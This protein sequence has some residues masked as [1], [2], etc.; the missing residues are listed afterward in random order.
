VSIHYVLNNKVKLAGFF[1]CRAGKV[2]L[3][4]DLVI[5]PITISENK[6]RLLI[7]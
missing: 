2:L 6:K 3:K 5:F 1:L 4:I 7:S